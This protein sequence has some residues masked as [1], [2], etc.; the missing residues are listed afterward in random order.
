MQDPHI[1]VAMFCMYS[2]Y[3]KKQIDDLI[4]IYFE[5]NCKT[6]DRIKIYAYISACGLLWSN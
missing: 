3:D 2:L 6:E 4:D 1:D 5:N